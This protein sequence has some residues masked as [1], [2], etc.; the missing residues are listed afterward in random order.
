[1]LSVIMLSV[2]TL[3]AIMLN[4]IMLNGIMLNV[5]VL[6]MMAPFQHISTSK[7]TT[8]KMANCGSI[9]GRTLASSCQGLGFES[10][11]CIFSQVLPFCE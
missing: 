7:I 2:I 8:I 11:G 5:I 10:R 6:K 1:M 9:S 4:V 3:N